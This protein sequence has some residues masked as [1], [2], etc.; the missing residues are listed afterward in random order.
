M[1]RAPAKSCPAL[2]RLFGDAE[3]SMIAAFLQMRVFDK[4]TWLVDY[5]FD[6]DETDGNVPAAAM[7]REQRKEKLSPL[8]TEAARIVTMSS[9]RGQFALD[10]L[11]R[12]KLT[13][14][15]KREFEGQRDALARSLWAYLKEPMLFEAA[16]N[17]LHL[18]LYRRYD[19]HYQTFMVAPVEDGAA[20][21]ASS[22]LDTLLDDLRDRLD[23]GDGYEVDRFAIP[24]DGD[25]PA[26]V[27][28]LVVHPEAPTSVRELHDD[29]QRTTMYFR[30]P[31]EIMIVHT[32]STGRVHVRAGTRKLR[33][34]AAESFIRTVLEQEPSQQPVDFQAYDIARFFNGFDL[35]LPEFDDASILRARVIRADI[36]IGHLANRLS[37]S[38]SLDE[39]IGQLIS[40]QPG[41][42]RI[43]RNALAMRFVEIAV[44][45]RRAGVD[46]ERTLD[47]TLTDRNT[48][49]LLS[50]D[51]PFERVLGHRLLRHWGIL[52]DGRAPTPR[53]STAVLPALLALWNLASD[54]INGA[55]LHE[56]GVDVKTLLDLGFLVPS[57]WE[58][59][60][61]I[62]EEDDFGEHVAKVVERPEGLEL[63]S[64]DGQ[65]SSAAL[66]ERYRVYRIR[67]G[68]VAG[69]LR[70]QLGKALDITA[71]ENIRPDLIALGALEIDGRDV[72]LYLARRLEDERVRAA[73]DTELRA[74]DKQGIGL[75]LQAGDVAGVCLAANVLA[76]LADHILPEGAE[77]AVDLTSLTAAFRR[78]RSLAQGGAA[79]EFH[80]SGTGAGVLSVP[81]RG[82]IDIVGENRVTVIDRLV[83]AYPTPMKTEDM[84]AGF[85]GQSLSSIFGQPLWDKLKAG[86]MRSPKR[87]QWEI[88][89]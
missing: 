62:D 38:T 16:E 4:L 14:E 65:S 75:V 7:L 81:G 18:R 26:E 35:G 61:L 52:R 66:P 77:F 33:H 63:H 76:R 47:F 19:R 50:L 25:V 31:G 37:V 56:R 11:V 32:P 43:F 60:D 9:D 58:G 67:D 55:W 6:P 86:F 83:Q 68:W 45:Y 82:T 53:E 40:D 21:V 84:I 57:G 59:D 49:S 44:Q 42:E 46:G 79:V 30:P 64:S 24:Q 17:T 89:V 15:Q 87:G 73:I 22:A 13:T 85:G 39:D 78:N 80:K 2:F 8:E 1:V 74:R 88:A 3:A 20:D 23:R 10:G 29:G 70:E 41:L 34:D 12:S 54:R 72:P 48:T 71:M 28:Y 69:H 51:D 36:S 5:Y 27:M